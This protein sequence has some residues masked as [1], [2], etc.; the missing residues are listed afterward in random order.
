MNNTFNIVKS[1]RTIVTDEVTQSWSNNKL[2]YT[3]YKKYN[4]T[5]FEKVIRDPANLRQVWRDWWVYNRKAPNF[6]YQFIFYFSKQK[7]DLKMFNFLSQRPVRRAETT[8]WENLQIVYK[9]ICI[10]FFPI[11]AI[12][13]FSFFLF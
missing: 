8:C 12:N 11:L 7:I 10:N 4:K 3:N 5:S 9:H 1:D 6:A 2:E 13:V